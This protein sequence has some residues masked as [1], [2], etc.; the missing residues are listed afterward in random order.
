MLD[1][2]ARLLAAA[3]VYQALTEERPHRPA[4]TATAAAEHLQNEAKAGRLDRDA[5]A[6]VL[7]AAGH[8]PRPTRSSW[9]AGLT[10]REVD[11]MRLLARGRTRKQIA[12]SLYISESTVHTHTTHIYEKTG[13]S[14]RAG[15]ALFSIENDL[16]RT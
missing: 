12:T 10:D 1:T 8:A 14:N 13:L 11:V 7:D 5:V 6:A 9:P 15:V 4:F 16:I 3:D 2:P